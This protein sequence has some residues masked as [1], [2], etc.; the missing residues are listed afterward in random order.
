MDLPRPDYYPY[1]P[2]T[3]P[4]AFM[5]I[6]KFT[7]GR[8]HQ[9]R[10]GKSYLA[11]HTSWFDDRSHICPFCEETEED[12]DHAILHCPAKAEERAGCIPTLTDLGPSSVVWSSKEDLA[13]LLEYIKETNTGYPPRL[14]QVHNQWRFSSSPSFHSSPAST[15][16]PPL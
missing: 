2:S 7:A 14:V 1:P 5:K 13:N 3:V 10:A 11:A 9:M 4:N 15:P 6:N 8:L 16:P 12:F